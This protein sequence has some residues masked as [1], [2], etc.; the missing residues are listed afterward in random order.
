MRLIL[1][2]ILKVEQA[3][4]ELGGLTVLTGENNTGKS[5]VGK[6]LFSL[7]K[8]ANNVRRIDKY[9][10]LNQITSALVKLQ[11]MFNREEKLPQQLINIQSLSINLVDGVE[12][13]DKL[14]S[15]LIRDAET[16]GFPT[17]LQVMVQEYCAHI[18]QGLIRLENPQIAVKE[19]FDLISK[20]EFME[21][22]CSY[23][24]TS[25]YISFRDDTTDAF[26]SE[27]NILL[28]DDKVLE[29]KLHGNVSVEDITYIDS[30]LYLPILNTLVM[31][32]AIPPVSMRGISDS[33]RKDNIPYHLTDMADKLLTNYEDIIDLFNKDSHNQAY[34]DQLERIRSIIGGEFIVDNKTK[35][36]SFIEKGHNVSVVSVASGIKSFGIMQRLLKTNHIS[37]TK[38][39]I[40]DEPEIHLH[41]EWQVGFCRL[42]I[43][44]VAMGIPIVISSHSPYFV[45][46]LRYFAA[47]K[48]IERDVK[49]YMAEESD[50]SLIRFKEAKEDLNSVFTLLAAPLRNIMNVDAI[51][52]K[53]K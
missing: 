15:N 52:G 38:M 29:C 18:K 50:K 47:A 6:T 48:G 33:L 39:L 34:T 8:A 4:I 2:N 14:R 26:D 25:G 32:S 23:G 28:S 40:W 13:I 24:K 21:P 27:I 31:A 37:T 16:F 45:Q 10:T 42:I 44:L 20:S 12:D 11:R 35:Q 1:Q 36:M 22:L 17:R 19:E 7:L 53:L 51:R 49:Y 3:E 43:E 5:T 41:P 30:P 9:N 46:G